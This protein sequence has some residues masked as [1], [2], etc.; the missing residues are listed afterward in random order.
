MI[1]SC[2][3][4]R[5][6][7]RF[8]G[9]MYGPLGAFPGWRYGST[10]YTAFQKGSMSETRSFKT[11]RVFIGSTTKYPSRSKRGFACV[12]H[13]SPVRPFMLMAHDPQIAERQERRNERVG[14]R[15]EGISWRRSRTG[16]PGS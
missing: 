4:L 2:A 1:Q 15:E 9:T 10:S 14:S 11:G 13:D 6:S 7:I 8:L 12:L 3:I 5:R 16:R